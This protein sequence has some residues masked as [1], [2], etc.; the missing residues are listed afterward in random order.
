MVKGTIGKVE[1]YPKISN[2]SVSVS[3]SFTNF[4]EPSFKPQ[5]MYDE[6]FQLVE[7]DIVKISVEKLKEATSFPLVTSLT[8]M[9]P[10]CTSR[11]QIYLFPL[12][13]HTSKIILSK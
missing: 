10:A 6:S 4:I 1:F 2:E 7:P 13:K 9:Y 11:L 8:V 3:R 12:T 5:R